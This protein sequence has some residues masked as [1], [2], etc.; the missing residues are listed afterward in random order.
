MVERR[1]VVTVLAG[2][3]GAGK[4][5]IAG[6]TLRSFRGEYYNPD[7]AARAHREAHPGATVEDANAAAWEFGRSLLDE[8]IRDRKD[9][10]FETTLG[11]R[12]IASLLERAAG[13]GLDVRIWYVGLA[14]VELHLKRVQQR[15]RLGGHDIP[16]AMIRRRFENGPRNLI[17]L[18]PRLASLRVYDNSA[19]GDP[20]AGV[21]LKVLLIL[22]MEKR[23]I[24]GPKS[25]TLTPEW[26]K[27]IVA[28]AL[29]L[30]GEPRAR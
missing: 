17:R 21:A 1:A 8:A 3:N 18:M 22:H 14:T 4:S 13:A 7:E 30:H 28:R 20:A 29:E 19:P 27:P 2:T 25:L 12:T 24:V 23:R 5:S 9:F 16:E 26:A 11:G 10:A 6:A 15:V